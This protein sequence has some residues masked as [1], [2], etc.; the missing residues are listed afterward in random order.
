MSDTLVE[1]TAGNRL[2]L[3]VIVPVYNE[4]ENVEILYEEIQKSVSPLGRECEIVFVDDGS[5]DGTL[6][7]LRGLRMDEE[8]DGASRVTTHII[9]LARNFGQTAATQAGFDHAKGD[10]I[11]SMD[12]DLQNDPQ[13]IPMLLDKLEEGYDVV[14]GWRR[15]RKDKA[16]SRILPSKVANWLI[17]IITGV[18]IHDNGCSLRA[19]RS[20]VIKSIRLYSDMHRFITPMCTMVGARICEVVVLHRPRQHGKTKYG[21]SRIWKV[22]LDL[23]TIKMLIHFHYR[24]MRFFSLPILVSFFGAL[25]LGT[26]SIVAAA[27]GH[28]TIVLAGASLLLFFLFGS[29][30]SWG[31]LGEFLIKIRMGRDAVGVDSRAGGVRE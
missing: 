9:R 8:A 18:R 19:Y 13:D 5:S 24:P 16:L 23:L 11:V 29:V 28:Q 21:I 31:L 26:V 20:S 22:L 12:G 14:C 27:K 4:E 25:G 15:D 2:S 30:L 1:E 3:S 10:I 17:G 7:R 6:R